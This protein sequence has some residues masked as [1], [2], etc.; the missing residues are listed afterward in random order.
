MKYRIERLEKNVFWSILHNMVTRCYCRT[1]PRY[2]DYGARGIGVCDEWYDKV[3]GEHHLAEFERWCWANCWKPG[4][5]V[6][7]KDVNGDYSP[8][9]CQCVSP[10]QNVRIRRRTVNIQ[11]NGR[12]LCAKDWCAELG[13]DY[14]VFSIRKKNGWNLKTALLVPEGFRRPYECFFCGGKANLCVHPKAK[15]GA[16]CSFLRNMRACPTFFEVTLDNRKRLEECVAALVAEK[17]AEK[18]I[19]KVRKSLHAKKASRTDPVSPTPPVL[20]NQKDM[21]S[22]EGA[23]SFP[24]EPSAIESFAKQKIQVVDEDFVNKSYRDGTPVRPVKKVH[25]SEFKKKLP[26]LLIPR[27]DG[28]DVIEINVFGRRVIV[29]RTGEIFAYKP[30]REAWSRLNHIC[31]ER[32][33]PKGKGHGIYVEMHSNCD[34]F[35]NAQQT[36][37]PH[38]I[39][40][41]TLF[42]IAFLS[43][44]VDLG[45]DGYCVE[46]IDGNNFNNE[47]SNLRWISRERC[48]KTIIKKTIP[49]GSQYGLFTVLENVDR[50]EI[51]PQT[52]RKFKRSYVRCRCVCGRE[53]V[54]VNPNLT[55]KA[56]F[57]AA[58]K[59]C[60]NV[61]GSRALSQFMA[62]HGLRVSCGLTNRGRVK[63]RYVPISAESEMAKRIV[64]EFAVFTSCFK[65]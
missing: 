10:A 58:C 25:V 50:E 38:S 52:G 11:F 13:V 21:C 32:R 35:G 23:T 39:S 28:K 19:A 26:P 53:E 42:A 29:C 62:R 14:K 51:A 24:K 33:G 55:N 1:T 43:H 64:A 57:V 16:K 18:K 63:C 54:V 34:R 31:E 12:T 27:V 47:L 46:H 41:A 5:H 9:N 30:K 15:R 65:R 49:V 45:E 56:D 6:G 20:K 60:K 59:S 8:E 3:T 22:S 36:S 44:G 37:R 17:K 40:V 7:R 48:Y 4:C 61:Y 2:K